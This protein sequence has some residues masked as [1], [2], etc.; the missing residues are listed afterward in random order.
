MYFLVIKK[1]NSTK[2][3]NLNEVLFI[4][5]SKESNEVRITVNRQHHTG[6]FIHEIFEMG[7]LS[8]CKLEEIVKNNIIQFE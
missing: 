3:I 2:I 1:Q 6:G 4:S 7:E 5:K 8:V